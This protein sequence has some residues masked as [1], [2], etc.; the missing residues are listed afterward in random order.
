VIG[1]STYNFAGIARAAIDCGAAMQ[2]NDAAAIVDAVATLLDDASRRARMAQAGN[3][4]LA[5]H[6]GATERTIAWVRSRLETR[7]QA[8]KRSG[9]R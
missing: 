4:L 2:V 1:P 7:Q 3:D 8:Q 6:R 9:S 5:A